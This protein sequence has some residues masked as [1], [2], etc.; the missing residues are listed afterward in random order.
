MTSIRFMIV[1]NTVQFNLGFTIDAFIGNKSQADYLK[2]L[3]AKYPT[4]DA[5]QSA[6]PD[7][8]SAQSIG[9]QAGFRSWFKELFNFAK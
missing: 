8:L 6:Y 4:C 3:Q 1:L 2:D 7:N 9:K 5:L